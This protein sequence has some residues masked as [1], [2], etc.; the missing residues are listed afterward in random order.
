MHWVI[1]LIAALLFLAAVYASARRGTIFTCTTF[2]DFKKEDHWTTFCKGIDSIRKQHSRTELDKIDKWLVINEWSAEPKENWA[3][4]M[5]AAYPFIEFIQKTEGQKGQANSLNMIIDRIAPYEFWIQWE[6]SWFTTAPFIGRASD[7]MKTTDIVQLQMTTTGGEIDWIDTPDAACNGL[8]CRIQQPNPDFLKN[9]P[10]EIGLG[11]SLIPV[12]PLYS[13]R[14][15]INRASFYQTYFSTDPILW[16]GRFEWEYGV[17]WYRDHGVK[18]IL[19]D[20]PV[21]RSDKHVSTYA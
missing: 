8:F 19:P 7:I 13:L 9:S 18:A 17:R 16:P 4:K 12:W 6:E 15:S 1:V 5:A 2:F 14:P 11:G 10:Y 3:A 20:G 21:R